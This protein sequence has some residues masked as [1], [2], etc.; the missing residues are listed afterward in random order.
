MTITANIYM[1]IV[2]AN[3]RYD[4]V[5]YQQVLLRKICSHEKTV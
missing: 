1:Q 3:N 5:N 2:I 4:E